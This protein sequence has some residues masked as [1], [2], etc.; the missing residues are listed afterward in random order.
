MPGRL[1]LAVLLAVLAAIGLASLLPDLEGWLKAAAVAPLLIV[2][3]HRIVIA[4]VAVP[5][6]VEV[7]GFALGALVVPIAV[8]LGVDVLWG[9][10][11]LARPAAGASLLI[12]VVV[13]GLAAWAYL[14]SWW[15]PEATPQA[16]LWAVGVAAA[17][18]LVP[19]VGVWLYGEVHGDPGSLPGDVPAVSTLDVIVLRGGPGVPAPGSPHRRG[20]EIRTWNGRVDGDRII[21]GTA[22]APPAVSSDHADRVLLL[23]VDGGPDALTPD[24]GGTEA[25][26]IARPARDEVARWLALADEATPRSTPTY[27]VLRT[28]DPSRLESWH[29]A[30]TDTAQ[31]DARHGD[32]LGPQDLGRATDTTELALRL[33]VLDPA[34]DEDLALAA[35]HRPVLLF[36]SAERYR[37]P[38]NV[39][40]LLR[41]GKI[42]Q[43]LRGQPL[44]RLC[45]PLHS[46]ADFDPD[47]TNL[48]F[49]A[50]ELA[51]VGADST[52]Y[53]NVT[54]S[55]N[56]RPNAIYLDYWWYLPD[57]PTGAAGGA[58]C[59][60][61]FVIAGVTCHDHQSDWEGV[62]VTLDGD[63]PADAPPLAISYA[64]H[65]GVVRYTWRA[66]QELWRRS[67]SRRLAAGLDT[68]MRPLVFV[69]R[70][71]HAAYPV[72]CHERKC[73]VG[74]APGIRAPKPL[75]ENRHDGGRAWPGNDEAA[76]KAI[77]LEAL[78]T[79]NGGRDAA[80]WNAF[81]GVWGS[82]SCVLGIA[83]TS[84]KAPPSPAGQSRYQQ[85][86]CRAGG[87]DYDGARFVPTPKSCPPQRASAD[88][89]RSGERLVALGD[90]FSSG[91]GGGHY[92]PGTDGGANTC[93]RSAGAWPQLLARR[94]HL[95]ALQSLACSGAVAAQVTRDGVGDQAERRISQV[96]RIVEDPGV[97]TITIGGNDLGFA[98]VIRECLLGAT[99]CVRTFHKPSGDV[100]DAR[101]ARLRRT[102]PGVYAAIR[103][104]APRARVVVSGY[105]RLFPG[106]DAERPLGD[107][108]L[109]RALPGSETTYL[110]D[111]TAALNVAIADSAREAGVDFVDVTDAFDGH[112][113]RCHGMSYVNP[114]RANLALV[115]ASFHPNGPG[116]ARLAEVVAQGL[117]RRE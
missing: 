37:T 1:V 85:P 88:A 74:G 71:T 42:R 115:P 103:R 114:P 8:L 106:G 21:W 33:G 6:A 34:S 86:W 3:V 73:T 22:G 107:C 7:A 11:P 79:H 41:S 100:L 76:C 116:Y 66:A 96:S 102:L 83:C 105:P 111:R 117:P 31:G 94:M 36:D 70:G 101:I 77:C 28:G 12:G 90:S 54:R 27:A 92:E 61:G 113:L 44:A 112:E 87:F 13:V 26:A 64:Q 98:P 16:V 48:S 40:Q 108:V 20:W 91:Q 23:Y 59:G 19:P 45:P 53:V 99:N 47:A 5:P 39:D 84:S 81:G 17:L 52:I 55:G 35:Q 93:F 82:Q 25:P 30:L 95:V 65:D 38:L 29:D 68:S 80:R 69:A 109:G 49:S 51:R 63:A 78:P 50:D 18:M 58:L 4:V 24:V 60:A 67:E 10:S 43:C 110:N 14:R 62:T 9:A 104:R 15:V 2:V 32:A 89:I 97:V 75:P 46:S 56:D 72:S 57:N